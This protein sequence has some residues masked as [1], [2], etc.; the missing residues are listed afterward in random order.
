MASLPL[1]PTEVLVQIFKN[2]ALNS[3]DHARCA[4]ACKRFRDIIYY[5]GS[6]GLDYVFQVDHITQS[7]WKFARVLLANPQG[8]QR[9]R[10]IRVEWHRRERRW[11]GSWTPLWTWTEEELSKI[12]DI[13]EQWK[14]RS[15]YPA[16]R[17]GF[18][19]EALLPF[20]LCFTK[21][22]K[23]L[24]IGPISKELIH[25]GPHGYR[26]IDIRRMFNYKREDGERWN[27]QRWYDS[28]GATINKRGKS[29]RNSILW[30]YSTM[31]S[32]PWLPGFASLREFSSG[33]RPGILDQRVSRDDL[34]VIHLAKLAALPCLETLRIHN[35]GCAAELEID[36]NDD[37][38]PTQPS[39]LKHFELINCIYLKN[40]CERIAVLARDSLESFTQAGAHGSCNGYLYSLEWTLG[41]D[42]PDE[43]RKAQVTIENEISDV[44]QQ[45]QMKK[46][47]RDKICFTEPEDQCCQFEYYSS[48]W[49]SFEDRRMGFKDP[50]MQKKKH[51][52]NWDSDDAMGSDHYD[53][54]KVKV[55]YEAGE[56]SFW[57]PEDFEPQVI[58]DYNESTKT[59]HVKGRKRRSHFVG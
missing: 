41:R 19:S 24:D 38:K 44:F 57:L 16:I 8:G 51:D 5:S 36:P 35:L 53:I 33:N 3:G 43:I 55:Y 13:C 49:D 31:T 45:V 4:R 28:G 27:V 46:L 39:S 14:I 54:N 34:P 25:N 20:I 11:K 47:T 21:D 59:R 50:Y 10:E 56:D 15:I 40:I 22:L 9:I 30:I 48:D 1:F 52:V 6:F 7:T 37:P 29:R 42:D 32:E 23:V 26:L 58:E 17:D 12:W 2:K 18:N